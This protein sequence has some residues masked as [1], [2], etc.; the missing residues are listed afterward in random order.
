MRALSPH[1]LS[2]QPLL[3]PYWKHFFRRKLLLRSL[4]LSLTL[5]S[6]S[7]MHQNAQTGYMVIVSTSLNKRLMNFLYTVAL[8][9]LFYQHLLPPSL[10]LP[11]LLN[12]FIL[13]LQH[14][15]I[16]FPFFFSLKTFYFND[17][18][19]FYKLLLLVSQYLPNII[20]ITLSSNISSSVISIENYL[21]FHKDHNR[22]G[23]DV[24]LL[25]PI[26]FPN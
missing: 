6:A 23:G 13:I 3:L 20:C 17:R 5:L 7:V 21:L 8:S 24:A 11:N 14:L 10:I 19:L 15:P 12:C 4:K 18:R 1:A 16:H 26:S 9:V 25:I 2:L 22:H